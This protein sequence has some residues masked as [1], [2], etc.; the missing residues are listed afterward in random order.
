MA[1]YINTLRANGKAHALT[2]PPGV[3][4]AL[5]WNRGDLLMLEVA[6]D[7]TLIIHSEKKVQEFLRSRAPESARDY[8]AAE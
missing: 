6:P 4:R 5:H 3:L 2:I 7:D 8:G 1:Y